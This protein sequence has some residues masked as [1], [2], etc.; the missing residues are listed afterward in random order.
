M[1]KDSSAWKQHHKIKREA[2]KFKPDVNI[3]QAN[4]TSHFTFIASCW[5]YTCIFS[6]A[7]VIVGCSTMTT[8][9]FFD[10]S[11]RSEFEKATPT[12]MLKKILL[13]L[14]K[15]IGNTQHLVVVSLFPFCCE[16]AISVMALETKDLSGR[17]LTLLC[18]DDVTPYFVFHKTKRF[19]NAL[20]FCSSFIFSGLHIVR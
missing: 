15:A 8:M 7:I 13:N 14:N 19:R 5:M 10:R 11:R 20:F 4:T 3:W 12:T 17:F 6:A 18:G 9:K 2:T 16:Y 1:Q